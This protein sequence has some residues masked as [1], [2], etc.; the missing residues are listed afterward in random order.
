MA[1]TPLTSF[2]SLLRLACLVHYALK[3]GLLIRWQLIIPVGHRLF[4]VVLQGVLQ[5]VLLVGR[6]LLVPRD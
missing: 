5:G 3:L 6:K 1:L 2:C 4:E